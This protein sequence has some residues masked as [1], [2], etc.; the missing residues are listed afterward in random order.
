MQ[1][2]LSKELWDEFEK[3]LGLLS[4]LEH[5]KSTRTKLKGFCEFMKTHPDY[6]FNQEGMAELRCLKVSTLNDI[7][8]FM[9]PDDFVVPPLYQDASLGITSLIGRYVL[10]IK[11]STGEICGLVGYDAFEKPKYLDSKTSGYK[12]KRTTMFGM[13]KMLEYLEGDFPI[14]VTEG[15]M[16]ALWLRERGFAS[17][18]ILGSNLS[19]DLIRILKRFG[20]RLWIVPDNDEAGDNFN[21]KLSYK[22]PEANILS[23]SSNKDIDDIRKTV[24]DEIVVTMLNEI[25]LFGIQL[26]TC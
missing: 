23:I 16:C 20:K 22:L 19:D 24:G 18:S 26:R 15:T 11:T 6:E 1:D 14:F 21:S 5:V 13:E 7:G 25:V 10:P 3:H 2:F 17:F 9:I 4:D 12:A 8:G